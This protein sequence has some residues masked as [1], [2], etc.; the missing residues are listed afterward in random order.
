MEHIAQAIEQETRKRLYER[1]EALMFSL[2]NY[3]RF[4]KTDLNAQVEFDCE[5]AIGTFERMV[6]EF[7]TLLQHTH[8]EVKA[9]MLNR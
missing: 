2:R 1:N 4:A 5:T 3:I 7:K 9:E 6:E 8:D